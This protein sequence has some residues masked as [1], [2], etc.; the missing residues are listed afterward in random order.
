MT[1]RDRNETT[2]NPPPCRGWNLANRILLGLALLGTF[3]PAAGTTQD[4]S[5]RPAWWPEPQREFFLDGPALLLNAAQ[6]ED[7]LAMNESD[8][9]SWIQ[10][11]LSRDPVAA[12]PENELQEAIDRRRTLV[13]QEFL[14]FQDDRAKLLF[15][16]GQPQERISID[17]D[18]V[19]VPIELW[20]YGAED[21]RRYLVLYSPGPE[22]TW[23]LWLPLDSKRVL[24]GREMEYWLEQYEELRQYISGRRF[25][26]QL[27]KDARTIDRITGIKGLF[28][29]QDG[30]PTNSDFSVYLD[31]P[32]ELEAWA[33]QA[34]STPLPEDPGE[35]A[36]DRVELVYPD[37]EGQRMRSRL[38]VHLPPASGVEPFFDAATGNA[39]YRLLVDGLLELEGKVFEEFKVR[40]NIPA[41]DEERALALVLERRLRPGQQFLVRLKVTDEIT[42]RSVHVARLV[43][44]PRVPEDVPEVPVSEQTLVALAED[45]EIKPIAGADSLVIVP[46]ESDVVLGLW[47][48]E[49][50]VTGENIEKVRF[51][52]DDQVQLVRS[53]AP[54]SAELRLAKY[55]VE[56]IIRVEGLDSEGEVLSSDELVINQQRGE[57]RVR[58][59]DPPRGNTAEGS[60]E[61]SAEVVV[62]EER[63]VTKVEFLVNGELQAELGSPPW[64]A[65]IEVPPSGGEGSVT[66]L[67]VVAELDDGARAEDV[68]FLNVPDFFDQ[69]EVDFV[70]LYTTVTDRSGAPVLGL[71]EDVFGIKEDGRPQEIGKFELVDDLPITVG[72]TIDTSGSMLEAL[73]EARRAAADF[74]ERIIT[75]RDRSFAVSFSNRPELLMPR[76][77]DVTAVE[78]SLNTLQAVGMTSLYDAVVTSLY[79]FRG[80]KGRRALVLLSD[81]EDTASTIPYADSLEY[82]RRSGVAIYAVGLNIGKL[83]SGVRGKLKQL[84]S[85]TGGRSFFISRAQEL[86]SVYA[87]IERELRSQYLLAYTSDRPSSEESGEDSFRSIEVT[88]KGSGLQART[89]SGYYP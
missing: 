16:H 87:Q 47:R 4:E 8:R 79:Y 39:E 57:L 37:L 88:V 22:R 36:M 45:L 3:F 20:G 53:R 80:V 61:A 52:V 38:T 25:D 31:P 21:Q 10:D 15:L 60:V 7:L 23:R 17:C 56:Q 2:P 75:P 73:G 9:A 1:T 26:L 63:R 19:F 28:D 44:V 30:R 67:T 71:T 13:R 64:R 89:I 59:V 43:D 54:W 86:E 69:V 49:V 24:Y 84:A 81:G 65:P 33:V 34:A 48:A 12:T 41:A 70:E 35:I 46:P 82:A 72:I 68:R 32:S 40:F 14:T 77:S 42:G 76:T 74:L 11:Y 6:R 50:L 85:E 58:I 83:Q 62:P 5:A 55:P 18:Q 51:T 29:N 27:C 66:Y 78:E